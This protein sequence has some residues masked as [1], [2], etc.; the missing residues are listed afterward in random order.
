MTN[1]TAA[2][3]YARALF[4]VSVKDFGPERVD[5]D[6]GRFAEIVDGHDTLNRVLLNPAVPV[7]S[8][9]AIVTELLDRLGDMAQP[10]A[11]LLT[12][13][14][15]RDRFVL[16]PDIVRAYRARLLD[17]QGVVEARVTTTKPMTSAQRAAIEHSLT[18]VSGRKV[19]MTAHVDPAIL[20]GVVAQCGATV[21][22]ASLA[23][24]LER[25]RASLLER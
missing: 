14:A 4:D 13:L 10:L 24:H 19:A 5:V 17:Y 16:L 8:K 25:M 2:A 6:L 1:R 15:D 21:Y 3:R 23:R 9:R 22:D 20:G 11:R 7:S 12:L 18:Q